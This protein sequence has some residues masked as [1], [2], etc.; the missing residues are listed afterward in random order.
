MASST[1]HESDQKFRSDAIERQLAHV[2]QN[3]VKGAY[4]HKAEYWDERVEMMDW[5][6]NMSTTKVS[7]AENYYS[8]W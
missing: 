2:E 8:S 3:K 5:W 4:S 1:L 7:N 6:G